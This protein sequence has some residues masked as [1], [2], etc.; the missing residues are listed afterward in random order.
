MP[1]RT[2]V[3]PALEFV[4]SDAYGVLRAEEMT[5]NQ[6]ELLAWP[7]FKPAFRRIYDALQVSDLGVTAAQMRAISFPYAASGRRAI[8]TNDDMVFGMARMYQMLRDEQHQGALQV[9]RTLEEAVAWVGIT[10]EQYNAIAA[11]VSDVPA[12]T[13]QTIDL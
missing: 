2:V 3:V 13:L 8:V 9:Y 12:G 5:A 1:V 11:K 6:V 4:L 7:D 10:M